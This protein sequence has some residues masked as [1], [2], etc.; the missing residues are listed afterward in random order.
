MGVEIDRLGHLRGFYGWRVW[1][2][3]VYVL[4]ELQHLDE[5]LGEM[6]AEIERGQEGEWYRVN[7][8]SI[9]AR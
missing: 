7:G 2:V 8:T 1:T 4:G 5:R 3:R 9:E 6:S